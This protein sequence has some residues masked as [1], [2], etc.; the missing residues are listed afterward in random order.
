MSLSFCIQKVESTGVGFSY[1][2]FNAF[3][4]RIA[5]SLGLK[6]IWPMVSGKDMY[7]TGRYK[8]IESTHPVYPLIDHDDNDGDMGPDDCGQ[9]AA[10]L[11]TLFPE[12][13]RELEED[14]DED[15]EE[16]IERGKKLAE[17]MKRCHENGDTLLFL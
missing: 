10:Y 5:R 7:M 13:E 15:L 2:G 16:D 12:W 6:D 14:P 3:R 8:E 9:V 1:S 4:H 11:E 17:L